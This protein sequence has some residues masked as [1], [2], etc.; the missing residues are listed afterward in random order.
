MARVE[1]ISSKGYYSK[2]YIDAYY[3]LVY[4]MFTDQII[5]QD[6]FAQLVYRWVDRIDN[7]N[8]SDQLEKCG[9]EIIH[10]ARCGIIDA[11]D[12]EFY[13]NKLVKE[14]KHNGDVD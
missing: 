11:D 6:E 9:R 2:A 7:H 1:Q 10:L 5:T 13:L 14:M 4:D 12:T 3:S 8:R